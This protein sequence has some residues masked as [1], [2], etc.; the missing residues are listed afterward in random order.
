MNQQRIKQLSEKLANQIAA[1]EVIE[2]PASVIKELLENSLDAGATYIEVSLQKGGKQSIVITDNGYGIHPDDLSLSLSKHATSKISELQ[3]LFDIT[4]LGF[5]GEALAS[6]SAVSRLRIRSRYQEAQLAYQVFT[7]GLAQTAV[8]TPTSHPQGTTVT[9]EDLFFNVPA[10]RKFLRT[11]KTEFSHVLEVMTR[12]AL[13]ANN[14][15]FKLTHQDSVVWQLPVASDPIQ[16]EKRLYKLCGKSFIDES[17]MLDFSASGL[18]LQGYAGLPEGARSQPD[19]QYFYVNNRIVKDRLINHA[20]RQAYGERIFSGRYPCYVLYLTLDPK[21]VDVNVHPTKH[22]V[23]FQESRLVHDFIVSSIEKMLVSTLEV[24]TFPD[25]QPT[26]KFASSFIREDMKAWETPLTRM[27]QTPVTVVS[28]DKMEM[29]SLDERFVGILAD[30]F[31]LFESLNQLWIYDSHALRAQLQYHYFSQ[32][33]AMENPLMGKILLLPCVISLT[34]KQF[35]ASQKIS[36]VFAKLGFV[37][38]ESGPLQC[39]IR[40]IPEVLMPENVKACFLAVLNQYVQEPKHFPWQVLLN[41][42][43]MSEELLTEKSCFDLLKEAKAC[44]SQDLLKK[45]GAQ[46]SMDRFVTQ[47]YLSD[48]AFVKNA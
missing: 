37:I 23:R 25:R 15:G 13:C 32:H 41:F 48:E 31:M 47:A 22:E 27:Y 14:V 3:D 39:I 33:S 45:H 12:I 1:G 24:K 29:V 9:V 6:I 46:F 4:S 19:L 44:L 35:L 10:R 42:T 38:D 40:K 20:I 43:V 18:H 21:E 5:R 7:E 8:I 36:G 17:L 30:R 28:Q 26:P 34:E 2:R 16:R 11:D